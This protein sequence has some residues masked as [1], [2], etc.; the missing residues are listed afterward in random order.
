MGG[1]NTPHLNPLPYTTTA[2]ATGVRRVACRQTPLRLTRLPQ[3][4][5][6]RNPP[7]PRLRRDWV[8]CGK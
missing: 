7:L 4:E 5:R 6:K 3:G 8:P 2:F 1:S